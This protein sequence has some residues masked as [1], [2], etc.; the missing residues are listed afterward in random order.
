MIDKLIKQQLYYVIKYNK[1]KGYK[2]NGAVST[3][4][5]NQLIELIKKY[6][7]KLPDEI[8]EFKTNSNKNNVITKM[9]DEE[10][11]E[12]VTNQLK[13][14]AMI[15]NNDIN[16]Q[17]HQFEFVKYFCLSNLKG[18][19]AF[20]GTGTGKTLTAVV[21]S[22]LYLSLYP[23]NK[24]VVISPSALLYNF[25]DALKQF[26]LNSS[27]KRYNFYSYDKYI[28]NKEVGDNS[29][30][31]ID[32]AHN[33]RSQII[34]QHFEN[35]DTGKE[36]VEV[37]KNKKGYTIK[38][39]ASDKAHKVLLLTA[40][41]FVNTLYDIENLLAMVDQREPNLQSTFYTMCA[42][43]SLIYDY[44]KYRISHYEKSQTSE[45]FPKRIEKVIPIYLQEDDMNDY[46]SSLNEM[47]KAFY[48]GA[49]QLSNIFKDVD[50]YKIIYVVQKILENSKSKNIIYTGFNSS[51]VKLLTKLLNQNDISYK[52]ISGDKNAKEKELSKKYYNYYNFDEKNIKD[53][54]D[55]KY[56]N[57]KFRVLIITKAG[58][59][60][61][62][63]IATNN[64]F[65][66]D[67]NWNEATAEQI[68][69]RAIRYKSHHTLPKNKRFVNVY[70]LLLV[71]PSDKEI[72]EK[73]QSPDFNDYEIIAKSFKEDRKKLNKLNIEK[74][75][76]KVKVKDALSIMKENEL[77]EY[78]KLKTKEERQLYIQ[79]LEFSRYKNK[80]S[81]SI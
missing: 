55:R 34:A 4:K 8:P 54:T 65:L 35:P 13:N 12:Y 16:L 52:I 43:D 19:I 62:D 9:G 17:D 57:D 76:G 29:L 78:K 39:F 31:I 58:A 60:G 45:Y 70:R 36:E 51:G 72:I 73:I 23:N 49:R 80:Y 22:N 37:K 20:H 3:M 15:S 42:S 40:T 77:V 41:P 18:G 5:K 47:S 33:F 38:T 1:N 24:V 64:I 2:I 11:N 67:P 44:M 81:S 71:K 69:A 74:S 25:I 53:D 50:N 48:S 10:Q 32:E 26:G 61:V 28:R 46:N 63:T 27:D 59:E 30:V 79:N 56:I 6:K 68:I 75:S 7:L 14:N 66:L 21:T